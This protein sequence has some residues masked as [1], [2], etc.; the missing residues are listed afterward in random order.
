MTCTVKTLD[1][2]RCPRIDNLD[3]LA[4]E[5]VGGEGAPRRTHAEGLLDGIEAVAAPVGQL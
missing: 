3:A 4:N 5:T 1:L 2:V